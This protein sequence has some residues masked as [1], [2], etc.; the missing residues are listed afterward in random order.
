MA[1]ASAATGCSLPFVRARPALVGLAVGRLLGGG[2]A[3]ARCGA[4]RPHR[5]AGR[6]RFFPPWFAYRGAAGRAAPGPR[7]APVLRPA[8]PATGP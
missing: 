3:R 7:R 1:G 2:W 5:R 8:P 4:V 6:D